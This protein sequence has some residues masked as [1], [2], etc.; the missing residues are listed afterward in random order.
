MFIESFI[1]LCHRHLT[2]NTL[3]LFNQN[4]SALGNKSKIKNLEYNFFQNK[5]L[6]LFL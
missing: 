6:S 5:S 2:P 3:N 1:N 4:K